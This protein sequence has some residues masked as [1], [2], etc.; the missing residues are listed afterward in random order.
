VPTVGQDV[1]IFIE[2]DGLH[3]QYLSQQELFRQS[4]TTSQQPTVEGD[5]STNGSGTSTVEG[6][7]LRVSGGN[8]TVDGCTLTVDGY[9][10][11]V[12]GD[13][14]TIED[15]T[16][17]VDNSTQ[18]FS[19]G[20]LTVGNGTSTVGGSTLMVGDGTSGVSSRRQHLDGRQSTS[21]RVHVLRLFHR[22]AKRLALQ[23][24]PPRSKKVQKA[25]VSASKSA[26]DSGLCDREIFCLSIFVLH[27]PNEIV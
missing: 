5:I 6:G 13:I 2:I 3:D 4:A 14:Q 15:S 20:I 8:S 23:L 25:H 7:I 18:M 27:M 17:T 16:L 26:P 12:G 21:S 24:L 19:G 9:T 11:I 10:L 1:K 22:Q